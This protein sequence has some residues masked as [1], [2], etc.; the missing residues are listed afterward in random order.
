MEEDIEGQMVKDFKAFLT[1]MRKEGLW[2]HS[3]GPETFNFKWVAFWEE[4]ANV[5]Q[6]VR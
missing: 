3:L 1:G 2:V 6:W 5:R 4:N